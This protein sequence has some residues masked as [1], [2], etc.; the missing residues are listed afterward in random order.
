[1]KLLLIA[2]TAL[3]LSAGDAP[4][5]RATLRGL[6]A[7]NVVL[8]RL[9]PEL[10]QEGLTQQDL[11]TRLETRLRDAQ[12]PLDTTAP[13]FV[14]LRVTSVRGNRGP[15]GLSFTLAAYQPVTLVRDKNVKT[16]APTW[17]V[18]TVV[19]A[20]PKVLRQASLESVDELAGRFI[21]AWKSVNR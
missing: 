1:M 18:E 7:V 5:D 20:D 8:D 12:I 21:S 6:K 4:L 9:A 15:F 19:V 10:T 16:A 2:L 17:D 14:G 11:Q 13:E 3:S